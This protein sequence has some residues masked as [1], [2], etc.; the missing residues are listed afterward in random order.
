MKNRKKEE[1]RKHFFMLSK[2]ICII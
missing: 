2:N 1:D